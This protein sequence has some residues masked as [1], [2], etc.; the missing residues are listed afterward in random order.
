MT[1]TLV[2]VGLRCEGVDGRNSIAQ[3]GINNAIR[4]LIVDPTFPASQL[5]VTTS[6]FISTSTQPL[7]PQGAL[8]RYLHR[9]EHT[10]Q[11]GFEALPNE[12]LFIRAGSP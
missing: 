6:S 2:S 10:Q 5:Y 3:K 4:I 1:N 8:A 11:R 7:L 9:M 12:V